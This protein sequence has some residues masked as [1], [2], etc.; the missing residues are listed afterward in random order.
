[1]CADLTELRALKKT[2]KL[3]FLS[4]NSNLAIIYESKCK[5]KEPNN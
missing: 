2:A 1:M 4:H 3:V 5:H